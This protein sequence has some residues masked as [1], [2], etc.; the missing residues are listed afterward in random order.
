MW[1]AC[2]SDVGRQEL[3]GL[4]RSAEADPD[5]Q[6]EFLQWLSRRPEFEEGAHLLVSYQL[7]ECEGFSN[8]AKLREL[9][10]LAFPPPN[11]GVHCLFLLGNSEHAPGIL[12]TMVGA[13]G[14]EVPTGD[15]GGRILPLNWTSSD[16][17]TSNALREAKHS[18]SRLFE[19]RGL[20]FWIGYILAGDF[21]PLTLLRFVRLL[22]LYPRIRRAF[23]KRNLYLR[24]NT[25]PTRYAGGPS[26]G[27]AACVAALTAL[28]TIPGRAKS[29]F[30]GRFVPALFSR[31]PGTALTGQLNN[32]QIERVD[33]VEQKLDAVREISDVR[34]VVIPKANR[35]SETTPSILTPTTVRDLIF[36]GRITP[37]ESA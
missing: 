14:P 3:L 6:A 27:L 15:L 8:W 25:T 19:M 35:D 7:V 33:G 24:I 4:L 12:K 16:G 13:F 10:Y 5:R 28:A 21:L 2:Q 22:A 31:L 20:P 36:A 9:T 11:C 29:R 1:L 23:C 30:L 17:P 34:R 32:D 18:A 26:L 37:V